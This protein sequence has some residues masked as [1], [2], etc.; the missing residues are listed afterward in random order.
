MAA[1]TRSAGGG[2]S[3]NPTTAPTCTLGT[4]SAGQVLQVL[5]ANG[6]ANTPPDRLTGTSVTSGELKWIRKAHAAGS[7]TTMNGSIWWARAKGNH[8][9]QTIIAATVN[10]GASCFDAFDGC[11]TSLGSLDT[12]ILADSPSFYAIMNETSGTTCVDAMGGTS[13]SYNATGV[14]LNRPSLLDGDARACV[15][16]NGSAGYAQ[17]AKRAAFNVGTTGTIE[18]VFYA[19]SDGRNNGLI[20]FGAGNP[21]V[22][23]T[24]GNVI[25]FRK[26]GTA[27]IVTSNITLRA[28]ML[29]HVAIKWNTTAGT[30]KIFVNGIDVTGTVTSQ[31]FTNASNPIN[32]GAADGGTTD[33]IDGRVCRAVYYQSELAD[34]R[35][36]SHYKTAVADPYD[37]C[38]ATG[39][40][41]ASTTATGNTTT[42]VDRL[43]IQAAAVDDDVLPTSENINGTTTNRHS[44]GVSTGGDDTAVWCNSLAKSTAGATGNY[45]ANGITSDFKVWFV[46]ALMPFAD[47]TAPVSTVLIG[48]TKTRI[49]RISG[50][51]ASDVTFEVDEDYSGYELRVV[52]SSGSTRASGSLI[53]SGGSGLAGA[54]RTVTVTDDELI[55]VVGDGTHI[56]KIFVQDTAGNWST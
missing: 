35:I 54:D 5:V 48:P 22:R 45:V 19:D 56:I 53:E 33:F 49:S 38:V 51:D 32:L 8:S 17:F 39:A 3:G 55:A 21:V 46:A 6:G 10:S 11:I 30:A 44:N 40:N 42:G 13:G 23:M 7:G 43:L 20:D 47:T 31:S 29:Y 50:Q 12:D 18:I 26:N 37:F 36:I 34:A 25:L 1:P 14:T 24:T 2:N 52:A 4:T 15:D 27:D 9:G 41:A 28:G 16:F